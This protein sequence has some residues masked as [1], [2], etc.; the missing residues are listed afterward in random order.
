MFIINIG[1]ILFSNQIIGAPNNWNNFLN[2]VSAIYSAFA[3]QGFLT[4]FTPSTTDY[5]HKEGSKTNLDNLLGQ[6]PFK[7]YNLFVNF[8]LDKKNT[9]VCDYGSGA[10]VKYGSKYDLI[11]AIESIDDLEK[12]ND[13]FGLKREKNMNSMRKEPFWKK[14]QLIYKADVFSKS[15]LLN[16]FDLDICSTSYDGC[17]VLCTVAWT[18]AFATNTFINY[19]GDANT[20][21]ERCIKYAGRGYNMVISPKCKDLYKM[22]IFL[23]QALKIYKAS[24]YQDMIPG[25]CQQMFE[26]INNKHKNDII[27]INQLQIFQLMNKIRLNKVFK[28]SL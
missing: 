3:Q 7:V 23:Y 2:D 19:G 13:P 15:Q 8:V 18:Q 12:M 20:Y 17:N 27:K 26:D 14:F 5:Y 11:Q 1:K 22:T 21:F 9:N 28:K 10:F 24:E 4:Y 6:R 16:H 25:I